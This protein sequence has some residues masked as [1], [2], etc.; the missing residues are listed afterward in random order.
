M[1]TAARSTKRERH[2]DD[3]REPW[4]RRRRD[5]RS[6]GGDDDAASLW[7]FWGADA[8]FV[9]FALALALLFWRWRAA[10]ARRRRRGYGLVPKDEAAARVFSTDSAVARRHPVEGTGFQMDAAEA[11]AL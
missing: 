2:R 1:L 7:V 3:E 5:G 8:A 4:Y 11:V 9:L 10:R 6:S